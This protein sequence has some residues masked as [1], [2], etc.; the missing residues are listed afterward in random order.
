M[1]QNPSESLIFNP[2]KAGLNQAS[3]NSVTEKIT[4]ASKNTLFSKDNLKDRRTL[5]NKSKI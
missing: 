3:V 5:K 1:D 4:E 2:N